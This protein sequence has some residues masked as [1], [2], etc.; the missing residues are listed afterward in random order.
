MSERK[1]PLELIGHIM[2]FYLSDELTESDKKKVLHLVDQVEQIDYT[3]LHACIDGIADCEAWEEI[4]PGYAIMVI[5]MTRMASAINVFIHSNIIVELNKPFNYKP[6]KS[7]KEDREAVQTGIENFMDFITHVIPLIVE[8]EIPG[9][10]VAM[11]TAM[12]KSKRTTESKG[13]VH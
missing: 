4:P 10:S 12:E 5:L 9:M 1:S 3:T 7:K 2:S 8:N 13:A 11:T 6:T